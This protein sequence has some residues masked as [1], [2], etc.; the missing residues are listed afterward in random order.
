MKT[1]IPGE[2]EKYLAEAI[3]SVLVQDIDDLEIIIVDDG[4]TD[5]TK[6]VIRSYG[7][8]VLYLYQQN[9][10]SGKARNTGIK[11]ASS[12]LIAF[13]DSDDYWDADHLDT[14]LQV[15][16]T[17]PEACLA[18]CGKN[19]VDQSGNQLP[20]APKQNYFPSGWI[21]SEMFEANYISTSSA[22]VV[23]KD[24]LQA[25]GCFGEGR[26]LRNA[27]DYH[28]WLRISAGYVIASSSQK[29]V[30]YRR[31]DTN[32]TRNVL[33]RQR[34]LFTALEM[35]GSLLRDGKVNNRNALGQINVHQRMQQYF[36]TAV[37]SLYHNRNYPAVREFCL[38]AI[39]RGYWSQRLV[40]RFFLTAL[41]TPL[42]NVIHS[43]R[44][45]L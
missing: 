8:R 25:V 21:F 4:S 34:G 45:I 14:M 16:Q 15:L 22:V 36:Q 42:R 29:T 1:V 2:D 30:N 26:E 27:Q 35:G 18:Y 5:N 43:L 31:H 40:S 7:D 44:N 41:P 13:L 9:A 39:K 12:E 19:W 28:L 11:N 23:R 10:G 37:T 20:D 24:V 17:H 33:S 6:E 38:L 3:D 32:K